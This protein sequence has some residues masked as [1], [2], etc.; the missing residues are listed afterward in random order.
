MN[1]KIQIGIIVILCAVCI[2]LGAM[3]HKGCARSTGASSTTRT[4]TLFVEKTVIKNIPVARWRVLTRTETRV[5]TA[6]VYAGEADEP[7]GGEPVGDTSF[8]RR[9][10]LIHGDTEVGV[11]WNESASVSYGPA[12]FRLEFAETPILIPD[13]DICPPSTVAGHSFWTDIL[14]VLAGFGAGALVLSLTR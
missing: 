2:G 10:T 9:G 8:V 12:G 1:T 4:D 6:Y 11:V 14:Y 5:D 13:V 7:Q 3:W